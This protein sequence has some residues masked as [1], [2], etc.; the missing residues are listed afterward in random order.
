MSFWRLGVRS[1]SALDISVGINNCRF[2]PRFAQI[3]PFTPL[4]FAIRSRMLP[5][6]GLLPALLIELLGPI[7]RHRR[8]FILHFL[9]TRPPW[10]CNET[11]TSRRER[12]VPCE[13]DTR[14]TLREQ[15]HAVVG[16]SPPAPHCPRY[17]LS[18]LLRATPEPSS[19]FIVLHRGVDLD[20]GLLPGPYRSMA[21]PSGTLSAHGPRL[22]VSPLC[23]VTTTS[24][25]RASRIVCVHA[26]PRL[27]LRPSPGVG[28]DHGPPGLRCR[29]YVGKIFVPAPSFS[30]VAPKVVV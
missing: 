28:N 16:K 1:I 22:R 15:R 25:L 12:A 8:L 6:L 30:E 27:G 9:C 23:V 17:W 3:T 14:L 7:E 20:H 19:A 2:F 13:E 4:L 21:P 11:N 18:E 29:L 5:S 24:A 10:V 26:I